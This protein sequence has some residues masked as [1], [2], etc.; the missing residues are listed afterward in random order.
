M[1]SMV[2]YNLA[3]AS[4]FAGVLVLGFIYFQLTRGNREST[5]K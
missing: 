2:V 4:V 1:I 5:V 3:I